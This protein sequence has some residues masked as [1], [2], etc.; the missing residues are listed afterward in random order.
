MV[1]CINYI[2]VRGQGDPNMEDGEYKQTIGML[3]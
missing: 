2:A 3:Y 1:P